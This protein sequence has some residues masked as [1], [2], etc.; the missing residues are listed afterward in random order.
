MV[1]LHVNKSIQY[2][3]L[4]LIG[5]QSLFHIYGM[6]NFYFGVVYVFTS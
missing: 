4:I 6:V 2:M 3:K 5:N 1:K